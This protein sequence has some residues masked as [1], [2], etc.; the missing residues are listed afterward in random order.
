MAF[1]ST[2]GGGQE[3]TT[4][5]IEVLTGAFSR[6]GSNRRAGAVFP[7]LTLSNRCLPYRGYALSSSMRMQ[8]TYYPGNPVATVQVLGSQE[9][10][11]TISG[12]WKQRFIGPNDVDYAAEPLI[13][14]KDIVDTVQRIKDM[15]QLVEVR[16]A[17]TVR[18]GIITKF[19]PKW[20][21]GT[22]CEWELTFSWTSR[23]QEP[24]Y[25]LSASMNFAAVL[26]K[27]SISAVNILDEA[28]REINAFSL[29]SDWLDG[30]LAFVDGVKDST[31]IVRNG[32]SAQL[33]RATAAVSTAIYAANTLQ[34]AGTLPADIG[35]AVAGTIS[36]QA[37]NIAT[38]AQSICYRSQLAYVRL[39]DNITATVAVAND[40]AVAAETSPATLAAGYRAAVLNA[41]A[42]MSRIRHTSLRARRTMVDAAADYRGPQTTNAAGNKISYSNILAVYTAKANDDLRR[43]AVVYYGTASGWQEIQ[44][45]NGLTTTALSAGQ[46][47]LIPQ[48]A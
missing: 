9:D 30:P 6:A 21:Y 37:D 23:G 24:E 20:N 14:V 44:K 17:D 45:Y 10:D 42:A 7:T 2:N 47:I 13:F 4:F 33:S 26:V 39:W 43:V 35:N 5:S 29:P 15:G 38:T 36:N 19:V 25:N 34:S 28:Q 40:V 1:E 46:I 3:A 32:V 41:A 16:W 12:Y 48:A 11:T 31:Q 18:R 8:K 22:D 27:N